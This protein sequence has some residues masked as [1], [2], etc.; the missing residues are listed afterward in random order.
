M[1]N[2]GSKVLVART[3]TSYNFSFADSSNLCFSNKRLKD[4]VPL[5]R[6]I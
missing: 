4:I 5:E 2:Y 3:E 6:V 1:V